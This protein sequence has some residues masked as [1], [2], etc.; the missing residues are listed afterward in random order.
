MIANTTKQILM[1]A[2]VAASLTGAVQAPAQAGSADRVN[3]IIHDLSPGH[4]SWGNRH[5]YRP[6]GY[7]RRHHYRPHHYRRHRSYSRRHYGRPHY[8]YASR[9]NRHYDYAPRSYSFAVHFAS[10]SAHLSPRDRAILDDL[11]HALSSRNLKGRKFLIVG[12]TDAAG[13]RH[14][15]QTLSELRAK[16]VRHYLLRHFHISPS[17]LIATGLGEERL[18]KPAHPYHGANRRVE[19]VLVEPGMNLRNYGVAGLY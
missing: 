18:L 10:G 3:A 11:G 17:R 4:G 14:S 9:Y 19:I 1:T 2:L 16:A 13:G 12:H 8:G 6:H 15:N 7:G 5:D